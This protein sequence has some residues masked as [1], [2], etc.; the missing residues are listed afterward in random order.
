MLNAPGQA[1]GDFATLRN[2]TLNGGAGTVARAGRRLRHVHR[3]RRQ[4]GCVLGV[5]GATEPSVYDL[6][7]LMLNGGAQAARRSARSS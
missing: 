4:R 3:E 5:A 2:L 6:Q 1:P 7:G